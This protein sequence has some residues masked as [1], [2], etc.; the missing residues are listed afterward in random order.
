MNRKN[1]VALLKNIYGKIKKEAT[2]VSSGPSY[3]DFLEPRQYNVLLSDHA[4]RY[5]EQSDQFEIIESP[6][7][8][9]IGEIYSSGT[10][11]Y[12][13]LMQIR[14]RWED[15][16]F[17][18]GTCTPSSQA[19]PITQIP[20]S[21]QASPS[22]ENI[23]VRDINEFFSQ[24]SES[25]TGAQSVS[26]SDEDFSSIQ[27]VRPSGGQLAEFSGGNWRYH[28][29]NLGEL[30]WFIENGVTDFIRL[31]GDGSGDLIDDPQSGISI[32]I[33]VQKRFVEG[34]GANFHRPSAHSG[35][36]FGQGY[37]RSI[38]TCN[39]LLSGGNCLVH[40]RWGADRT[41]YIV[42]AFLKETGAMT[43]LE[44]L[45]NYTIGFNRWQNKICENAS[46]LG[47]S[48][49]LDGFYPLDQFCAA[50]S[51]CDVCNKLDQLR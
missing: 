15:F 25:D 7:C 30:K 43:D 2:N 5:H 8:I 16:P 17:T 42:A 39:S 41:G 24:Y 33:D 35:Y 44:E 27:T 19:V 37:T 1:R 9:N 31:S 32:T 11:E 4:I 20:S 51:D 3:Y 28:Q 36:R 13:Q 49:Y 10:P 14:D 40:C 38:Q 18:G 48:K 12:N 50:H 29:P 34:L 6:G 23:P 22:D 47:Y 45:W 46:N 21:N 26:H